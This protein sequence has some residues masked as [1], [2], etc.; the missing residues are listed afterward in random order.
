MPTEPG[1]PAQALCDYEAS[2]PDELSFKRQDVITVLACD[3]DEVE[4]EDDEGQWYRS[5]LGEKVG[6]FPSDYVQVAGASQS[7]TAQGSCVVRICRQ[8]SLVSRSKR[9]FLTRC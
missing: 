1:Q 9:G 4:D 8:H 2:A 5:E 6:L 7:D 3:E